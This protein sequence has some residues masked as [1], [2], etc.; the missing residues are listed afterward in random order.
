[1]YFCEVLSYVTTLHMY[2]QGLKTSFR[3]PDPPLFAVENINDA[4][5]RSQILLAVN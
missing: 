4:D 3:S 1:M 2:V 5:W